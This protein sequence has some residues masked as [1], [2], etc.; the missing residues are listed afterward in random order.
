VGEFEIRRQTDS[1]QI[2][3]LVLKDSF[4]TPEKQAAL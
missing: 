1:S 3:T 2:D 4:E